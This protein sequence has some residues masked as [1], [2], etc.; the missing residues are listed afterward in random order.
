MDEDIEMD[1]PQISTLGEEETPEPQ[2][3]TNRTSK[4][5]VK[6]LMGNSKGSSDSRKAT[7][8][9]SEDDEDDEEDEEEDQLIDDDEEEAKPVAP[10]PPVTITV[11]STSAR[12]SP[13]GRGRG[14]GRG[15]G[16]RRG[17]KLG[18]Y[19][20]VHSAA[21]FVDSGPA[22]GLTKGAQSSPLVEGWTSGSPAGSVSTPPTGTVRKR[23]AGRGRGTV[24]RGGVRKRAPK[25]AKSVPAALLRDEG[26]NLSEG[27][28]AGTAASS[29]M[30][31][32][33][34][35]PEPDIITPATLPP[36]PPPE[37][38]NL[39]GVPI[40]SYPLPNKPF[41]VQPPVK[42][43]TGFAP[44]IPLD[45]SKKPVRHWRQAN[46]E[47]R[48]IAGGRWFI[49]SWIGD[50]ES[51]YATAHAA[52]VAAIQS[53]AHAAAAEQ[54]ALASG[55]VLLPKLPGVSISASASGKTTPRA[56]NIKPDAGI[57]TAD[58]SRAASSVPDTISAQPGSKKRGNAG[59]S[60][61]AIETPADVTP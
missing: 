48:G 46:R 25:L 38:V 26:D 19:S 36:I 20:F 18:E 53:A 21:G 11:P 23:G 30:P 49:R 51:E 8:V 56:K 58:T 15:G 28:Y 42:I 29:P 32:D 6:L 31:H 41:P 45:R 22:E 37:D 60:T 4:F 61:P 27:A 55:S 13:A 5:R 35:S 54:A 34:H 1:A 57:G 16:R 50:K 9:E 59:L 12:A 39:D 43:A 14:R 33:D 47:I 7:H 2:S 24:E 3:T 17:G 44:S 10:P 40:P 52:A